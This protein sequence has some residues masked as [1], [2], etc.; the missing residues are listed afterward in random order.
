M[1]QKTLIATSIAFLFSQG[2]A[3]ERTAIRS[4]DNRPCVTNYSTEGGFW[5]GKQ[6]KIFE[7]FPR[8]STATAFE[9]VAAAVASSGYQITSSNKDLGIISASQ[10]VSYS[11][12]GKTVPLNAVVRSSTAGGAL[13]ELLFSLSGGACHFCGFDSGR[14]L[15][16]TRIAIA[17]RLFRM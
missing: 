13:V 2:C 17:L 3:M 1:R 4:G 9:R 6:F 16:D 7:D 8:V 12:G 15:Q 11:S 5:T 14:V 10:A